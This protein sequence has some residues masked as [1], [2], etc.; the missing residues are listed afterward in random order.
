MLWGR[1]V[2]EGK[3]GKERT[4]EMEINIISRKKEKKRYSNV[5][6]RNLVRWEL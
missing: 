1:G 2:V 5:S 4:L 6:K 3:Q